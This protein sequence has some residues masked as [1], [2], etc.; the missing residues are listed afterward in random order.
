VSSFSD[1][2]DSENPYHFWPVI[3]TANR[4]SFL[5]LEYAQFK[6]QQE[7]FFYLSPKLFPKGYAAETEVRQW[8]LVSK[9]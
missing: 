5:T 2:Q 6:E 4:G 3:I 7:T 1:L 9:E 8:L